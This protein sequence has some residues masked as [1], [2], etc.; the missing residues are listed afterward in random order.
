MNLERRG[1]ELDTRCVMCNRRGEEGGH[2][3]FGCKSV[4]PI[5]QM[6]GFGE[7]REKLSNTFSARD[8]VRTILEFDERNILLAV[9]FMWQ[10]LLERNRVSG[11]EQRMEPSQL[12]YIA[13]KNTDKFQSI[14]GVCA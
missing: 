11:G 6:L 7:A 2:L 1:M 13:Q 4:R 14:V 8:A 9:T 12:A 3:F 10:W 5:W